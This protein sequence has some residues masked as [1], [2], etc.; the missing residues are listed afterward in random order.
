MN[1]RYSHPLA[2]LVQGMVFAMLLALAS[3]NCHAQF[4][5]GVQGSVQ[6]PSGRRIIGARITLT[7]TATQVSQAAVSDQLGVFHFINIPPGTYT[8][9]AEKAGFATSAVS[10]TVGTSQLRNVPFTLRVG[11]ATANVVVTT[12][13]P[14]LDTSDSRFQ[15]TMTA[16]EIE[17]LPNPGLSPLEDL[18]LAP[19]V[20]GEASGSNFSPQN[21]A[22]ISANGRGQNGNTISLDGIS[23]TDS[24]RPGVVNVTPNIDALQEISIQANTYSVQ[25]ASS[26]I[27]IETTTKSGTDRY[28]GDASWYY[29]YQGLN[30]RGEYGP[31]PSVPLAKYHTDNL[32]FDLG[33]PVPKVKQLFFFV[34]YNPY[35][36][37]SPSSTSTVEITDP[38]F[39]STYM[40]NNGNPSPEVKQMLQSY[41]QPTS[42]FI[43]LNQNDPANYETAAQAFNSGSCPSS[44]TLGPEYFNVSCNTVVNQYGLFNALGSTNAK[45]YSFRIDKAFKKDRAYVSFFRSTLDNTSPGVLPSAASFGNN[46]EYAVQGT[47]NYTFSPRLLNQATFGLTRAEGIFGEGDY[48]FN[49]TM[50][51]K[52]MATGYGRGTFQDGDYIIFNAHYRDL[53]TLLHGTHSI[54]LGAQGDHSW[55]PTFFATAYGIPEYTFYSPYDAANNLPDVEGGLSYDYATGQPLPYQYA[56]AT[57]TFAIFAGDTWKISQRLTINY[58][59]RYE[60]FGNPYSITANGAVVT[61]TILTNLQL[62]GTGSFQSAI[63]NASL[64]PVSNSFAHDLNWNFDPRIGLADDLFGN[65]KTVLRGGFGIYRDWVNLGNTTNQASTNPPNDYE[66]TFTRGVT[67][68]TPVFSVGTSNTY[69]FGYT[70]PTISPEPL[71]SHGGIVGSF[72]GIGGVDRNLK[73]PTTLNWT[74]GIGHQVLRDVTVGFT[75]EGSHSY[76]QIYGGQSQGLDKIGFDVNVFNGDTI[77]N[78]QFNGNGTWRQGFE[79]RLN[80]SFGSMQYVFNGARANYYGLTA[81]VKGRFSQH[82]FMV[83]SYTHGNAWDDWSL[84]WAGWQPDGSWNEDHQYAPSNLDIRER[85][86]AAFA[87]RLPG[88]TQGWRALRSTTSGFQISGAVRLETGSPFTVV[89]F[90]S[91]NLIDTVPGVQ[92][93]SSNYTSELAAGHVTYI[94]RDN[95]NSQNVQAAIAAGSLANT[96]ISGDYLG[97]GANFAVPNVV[98]Y[99]QNMSRGIFK[100]KCPVVDSGCAG[101]YQASQF[102][103]PAFAGSSGTQGNELL[104]RFREPGYEDVDIALEKDTHFW[105]EKDFRVRADFFN[106]LNRVNWGAWIPLLPTMTPRLARQRV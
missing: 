56:F 63:Q 36:A 38:S 33:G 18:D 99:T 43:L 49:P 1:G 106:A 78:P 19:G 87:Y 3:V 73:S 68:V 23:V 22:S 47:C 20:N 48:Y 34:A 65:G 4:S 21:F 96:G 91:L 69:P 9:S 10:F 28:H 2:G 27:Q 53:L 74:A 71:D 102:A 40:T 39:I 46:Y 60:N 84:G 44:G 51:I 42:K 55:D 72:I 66:P 79:T 85:G 93:T 94:T 59:L 103:P 50:S 41:N 11:T 13:E 57:T 58:G 30:A 45:Q 61:H 35:F 80:P 88:I 101:S 76:N 26:S 52:G 83:I 17:A 54:V 29:D 62:S 82:G 86:S 97:S 6:D 77:Q 92:L 104:Q 100:Y 105:H 8:A 90:N 5:A 89:D 24:T 98:S 81:E 25:S 14:L 67:S 70:Y 7:D 37:T 31:P 75:Y 95:L 32:S 16:P 15:Y 12:R 64:V